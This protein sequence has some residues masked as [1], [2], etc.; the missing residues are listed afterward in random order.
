[1][2]LVDAFCDTYRDACREED[3]DEVFTV[4][5]LRE[6]FSAW[7]LPKSPDPLPPYINE[8]EKRGFSMQTCWDGQPAVLC[9]R[10]KNTRSASASG[11]EP[12]RAVRMIADRD[13]ESR[14]CYSEE[15]EEEEEEDG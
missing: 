2:Q 11:E 9:Q 15:E 10:R 12:S 7:P 3:A 1:M 4:R 6:Y 8:L 13:T 14:E 5:R